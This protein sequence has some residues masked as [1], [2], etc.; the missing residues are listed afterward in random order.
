MAI[1]FSSI[2][3]NVPNNSLESTVISVLSDVD[4]RVKPRDTEACHRIGKP[5]SKTQKK[6]VRF[7]NRK[8]CEKFLANKKK[9]LKLSTEKYNFH[10]GIKIFVNEYLTSM[11][12][13]MAFSCKKLKRSGL[14]HS[15][16]SRNGVVHIKENEPGR[17]IKV[18]HLVKRFS[19][20]PDHLRNNDEN[21]RYHDVSI[22]ASISLQSSY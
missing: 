11:K 6:I 1:V 21:D 5:T 12:E 9:L 22:D 10:A 4:V 8:N 16:Y 20:F 13:T 18:F 2:P 17:P 7:I 3:M 19:L 14:I 15:C